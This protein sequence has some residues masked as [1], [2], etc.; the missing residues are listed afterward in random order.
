MTTQFTV[1]VIDK[2][3]G[4]RRLSDVMRRS[5]KTL[6]VGLPGSV[7]SEREPDSDLTLAS[8][9]AILEF[10]T[11]KAGVNHDVYIPPRPFLTGTIDAN[12]ENYKQITRQ[13]AA[14]VV[15]EETSLD[16]GIALLGER[17]VSDIKKNIV[18]GIPPGNA[19][20]TIL[21]KRSSTPLI[22]TGNLLANITYE[23]SE[24]E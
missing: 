11:D 21:K 2:D 6:A 14:Q 9:A 16:Q 20:S 3:K 7:G 18:A 15:A 17:I 22:D 13:I 5:K 19:T 23:I 4:F 8:L 10:G 12:L 1:K 24:A